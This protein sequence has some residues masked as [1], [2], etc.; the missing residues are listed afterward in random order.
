MP[1]F[2][3][4]NTQSEIPFWFTY[5]APGILLMFLGILGVMIACSLRQNITKS[6]TIAAIGNR[7]FQLDT[8]TSRY[9]LRNGI[10]ILDRSVGEEDPFSLFHFNWVDFYWQI[11]ANTNQATPQEIIKAQ[12]PLLALT[13]VK[14]PPLTYPPL[15]REPLQPPFPKPTPEMKSLRFTEPT[16][17]IYHTHTSES[18]LPVSGKEHLFNKK[19]DIVKVGAY[20]QKVLEE[21]HGIKTIHCDQ[22]HDQYPFRESYQR[23]QL[24]LLKYLKEYPSLKILLDLH[25]DATPGLNTTCAVNGAD[26]ATLMIVVG[27]DKMGLEHPNWKKN[28]EFAVKLNESLNK[29]YPSLSNGIIIADARYN[30]HLSERSLIIEFGNHQSELEQVFHAADLFAEVLAHIVQQELSSTLSTSTN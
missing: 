6:N 13:R 24:T 25:R 28:H 3:K 29:Y 11:A 2:S 27:S 18:Y 16:I 20:L 8:H 12:L 7:I 10:P 9:I 14:P 15:V 22:I 26:A 30:Q 1:E 21:K 19:G 17:L 4:K 23:S 5:G